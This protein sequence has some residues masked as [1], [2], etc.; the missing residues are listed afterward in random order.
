MQGS[1]WKTVAVV[2]VIGIGSLALLEVQSRLSNDNSTAEN[3]D[4][5]DAGAH[6]AT[7]GDQDIIGDMSNS[8]FDKFLNGEASP[9]A[10]ASS[11]TTQFEL[12]TEPPVATV[13][14]TKPDPGDVFN[15]EPVAAQ[16]AMPPVD[17][18]VNVA[19]LASGGNPFADT[20]N[21]VSAS[22]EVEE[23]KVASTV[24]PAGFTPEEEATP[25]E[26]E[27]TFATFGEEPPP[28]T[29]EPKPVSS[30]QLTP[31]PAATPEP[32]AADSANKFA[33]F[34]AGGDTA[35]ITKAATLAPEEQQVAALATAT[36]QF[37]E[38]E[39]PKPEPEPELN[40]AS[41]MFDEDSAT[42]PTTS[43]PGSDTFPGGTTPQPAPFDGQPKT[44]EPEPFSPTT[45]VEPFEDSVPLPKDPGRSRFETPEN[46]NAPTPSQN[47]DRGGFGSEPLPFIADDDSPSQPGSLSIPGMNEPFTESTQPSDEFSPRSDFGPEITPRDTRPFTPSMSEE[48]PIREF[49]SQRE[50]PVPQYNEP[51]DRMNDNVREFGADDGRFAPLPNRSRQSDPSFD[52]SFDSQ[53]DARPLDTR[54][55]TSDPFDS[56]GPEIRPLGD[57]LPGN[58]RE[59]PRNDIRTFDGQ[60]DGISN[61]QIPDSRL[62]SNTSVRQVSGKMSPNLVLEKTAPENATVG[63]PLDYHIFVKNEGDATAYDVVVDDDVTAAAK[64]EGAHPQSDFDKAAGKLIWNIG[65]IEPGETK[66][67]TVRVTPT[68]EGVL[69][70]TASVRF[71]SRV[72]ATTVITAPKLR[73]QMQGPEQEVRVGQE[74]AYRYIITNEGTGDARDVFIRTLLPAS[75]GLK[76]EAGRD[77]E[78]EIRA[79]KPGEQREIMLA[80]IAGEPGEHS[81]K[82]EV[83]A[84]GGAVA[85]AGWRTKVIG[86]Q[87]EIVRRGPKRRFVNRSATY[88][89]IIT[90][91]T[92]LEALDAKVVEQLPRGMKFMGATLGG[93]YNEATHTV[94]WV[95]NRLGPQRSEQLQLELMPTV[96]GNMESTV[97]ILENVGVQSD[98]YVSTTVV[99]D[100]H[101]V[102]AT[103][104]QLDGPVLMGEAFGF[105]INI[106][107]RGTAEATDV[108]LK[109]EVPPQIQVIGAGS[110]ETPAK[111]LE[112]S[113]IVQYS[114]IVRIAPNTQKS[115]ELKLRGNAAVENA[116]V[117]AM[118]N[119]KQ[120]NEP[121][122]ISESVTIY[123]ERL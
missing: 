51:G 103:I 120:M 54:P 90:N 21:A 82:A 100:I 83:T 35:G 28:A 74:V 42:T 116:A 88:E 117:K 64:I 49:D 86:A 7:T 123:D 37:Y 92:N 115:F 89:N 31:T 18:S 20:N 98:D 12:I 93:Q 87:L 81:A 15:S 22:Y 23:P 53:F 47:D 95:I 119:Y 67:I 27:T 104:S 33:F 113:N 68:G 85:T 36:A 40:D 25:F 61:L 106:D 110:R 38:D 43:Q 91:V 58:R 48:R 16:P 122:I 11:E 55:S 96:A 13:S 79:M 34:G 29:Q 44:F 65:E 1:F 30:N 75:G 57:R 105:T 77:L 56:R 84:T 73:L 32:E 62:R 14:A 78:Y 121:L 80:V 99:E 2:G 107:N 97:R 6:V 108:E 94:T 41:K 102:S 76:H 26:P 69:D 118:V 19:A 4:I 24:Q 39:N 5:H 8:D 66:K 63:S 52:R 50:T 111:L 71:K 112:G 46:R 72:K 59:T 10:T 3:G 60:P 9:G 45:D 70:G 109:V 101:N 114:V 17:T